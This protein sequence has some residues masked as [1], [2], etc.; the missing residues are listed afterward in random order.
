MDGWSDR[1]AIFLQVNLSLSWDLV[2]KA[3]IDLDASVALLSGDRELQDLV[4]Y[5]K[6]TSNNGAVQHSGDNRTG[7]GDGE[8]EVISIDLANIPL[9]V[10]YIVCM[11]TIYTE[12]GSF[13][14]VGHCVGLGGG[15]ER[16]KGGKVVWV[17]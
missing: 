1:D 15:G 9:E 7:R 10:Q 6:R 17:W 16:G 13:Q 8:D 11:A 4:F 5:N 3:A 2:G 14:Q 12:G